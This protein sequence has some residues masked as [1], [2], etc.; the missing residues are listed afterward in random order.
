M[1]CQSSNMKNIVVVEDGEPVKVFVECGNCGEYVCMYVLR[2]YTS[3][4]SFEG[5]LNILRGQIRTDRRG[6]SSEIAY[7]SETLKR[8][9]DDALKAA[10][11]SS[12]KRRVEQIIQETDIKE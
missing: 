9:F 7:F 11:S 2:R 5:L 10:K 3:D 6:R 1:N 4:Q 12:E 8:Q